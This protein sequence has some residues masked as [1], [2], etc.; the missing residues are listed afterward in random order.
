MM[1]VD[2]IIRKQRL[3]SGC[4]ITTII[5]NLLLRYNSIC[6]LLRVIGCRVYSLSSQIPS[7]SI[8]PCLL[9]CLFPEQN[10]IIVSWIV[11]PFLSNYGF[12]SFIIFLKTALQQLMNWW[13]GTCSLFKNHFPEEQWNIAHLWILNGRR[14]RCDW[15]IKWRI[16]QKKLWNVNN[17]CSGRERSNN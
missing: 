15:N 10:S 13:L 11:L 2:L 12:A 16:C 14:K 8:A 9:Y 1:L 3:V 4:N 7:E 17:V 5:P 6:L